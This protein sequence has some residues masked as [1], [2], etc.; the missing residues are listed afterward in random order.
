MLNAEA[1]PSHHSAGAGRLLDGWRGFSDGWLLLDM[2]CVLL[3][4]LAL[5]A[6]I[7]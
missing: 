3:L 6:V 4:A 1:A 5:G 2:A 7:A